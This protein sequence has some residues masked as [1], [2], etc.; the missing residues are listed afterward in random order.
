MQKIFATRQNKSK[1]THFSVIDDG[2]VDA[3]E[4]VADDAVEKW[5]VNR[6]QL[7]NIHVFHSQKQNLKTK[8]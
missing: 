7:G 3:G 4:Q 8:D 5:K 2:G 1:Q 6:G